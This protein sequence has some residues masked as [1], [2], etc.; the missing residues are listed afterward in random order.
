MIVEILQNDRITLEI[1]GDY[2]YIDKL[3]IME[4]KCE[5]PNDPFGRLSSK[6]NELVIEIISEIILNI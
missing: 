1:E 2:L 3:K 5:K 4:F 6:Y